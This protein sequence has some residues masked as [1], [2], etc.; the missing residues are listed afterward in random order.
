M[1]LIL[2]KHSGMDK[3]SNTDLQLCVL[4]C[5]HVDQTEKYLSSATDPVP[6]RLSLSLLALPIIY[7]IH[8]ILEHFLLW[9]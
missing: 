8:L 5:F 4:G 6:N 1:L 3:D 7:F 9:G 2:R